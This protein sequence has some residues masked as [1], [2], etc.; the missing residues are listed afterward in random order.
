MAN[1]ASA[2]SS[3]LRS[4]G[5]HSSVDS[6]NGVLLL[7]GIR[8]GHGKELCFW[9]LIVAALIGLLLAGVA[10]LLTR[11]SR[12]LLISEGIRPETARTI[13]RIALAQPKVSERFSMI[14]RWFIE[15]GFG[16]LVAA[17]RD[18]CSGRSAGCGVTRCGQ[19]GAVVSACTGASSGSRPMRSYSAITCAPSRSKVAANSRL[20]ST[21]M[22]VV[23]EP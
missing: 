9:S 13:R 10:T 17:G 3:A 12:G 20:S 11:A 23:S 19:R 21:A 8:L 2:G 22:A 1:V 16:A 5:I 6:F 18:P 7:V 4:E 14:R 15:A